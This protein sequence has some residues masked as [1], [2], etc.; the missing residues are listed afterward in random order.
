MKK[1]LC[2]TLI[3]HF[4]LSNTLSAQQQPAAI[5]SAISGVTVFLKGAEVQRT[6]SVILKEG[7]QQLIFENLPQRIN[8][9]SIQVSGVGKFTILGV[10]HHLNHLQPAG[11]T[12]EVAALEDSLRVLNEN[13]AQ[14]EA[15]LGVIRE[16]QEMLKANRY[17]GGANTGVRLLE[18]KSFADYFGAQLNALSK[19]MVRTQAGLQT[20]KKA[21]ERIEKQLKE[22][23]QRPQTP[24]SEI[25]VDITAPAATKATLTASYL[26]YDAG[27]TPAYDL[28]SAEVHQPVKLIYKAYVY[29]STGE[30]WTAV[31]PVFS[32]GNPTLNQ[33]KPILMPWYLS[34]YEP[35]DA[36]V[37]GY[38][39]ARQKAVTGVEKLQAEAL[40]FSK[41]VAADAQTAAGF[42]RVSESQTNV[43]FI[44]DVPYTIASD[45]REHAVELATY[46]LPAKYE[47]HAVRK[48]EKDVFLIAKVTD[49]ESLNLLSGQASLF[50]EDKYVGKSYIETRQTDD[51]LTLSLGRDKNITITRVRKKD[52]SE[53]Q[54]LG[55][56]V[57]ETREWELTVHNKKKQPAIVTVEDQVPVS[58]DKEIKVETLEISG[59]QHDYPTGKLT[60]RL[61]LKPSESRSMTLKYTVRRP[62][63][64]KVVLE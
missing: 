42:T 52:F 8:P 35:N 56:N 36:V 48:L 3:A 64:R 19:R 43:E 14:Q 57:T 37:V 23:Q 15:E 38:G 13:M 25:V 22:L 46:A 9:Q 21:A 54:F 55:N 7:A 20:L 58:T 63:N 24:T 31:N 34:F 32:T 26:A 50:F 11:K 45:G 51:T 59:A 47:Y 41:A 60:W 61:E 30:A 39:T 2:F 33:A 29:Q 53:K 28:R 12:K 62:K 49:W 44:V 6:G 27:W 10:S 4:I 5:P 18:I 16:E 1:L 40:T 17:I